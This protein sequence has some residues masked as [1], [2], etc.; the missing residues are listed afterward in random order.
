[1]PKPVENIAQYRE[2]ETLA[3]HTTARIFEVFEGFWLI[4]S[5]RIPSVCTT[6]FKDLVSLVACFNVNITLRS[7]NVSRRRER[8]EI[9]YY[10]I[11]NP[12]LYRVMHKGSPIAG[13][14]HK[15]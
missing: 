13:G 12:N 5:S 14:I 2:T 3:L 11:E 7:T 9:F 15:P 4:S 1:M 6:S 8:L 10:I